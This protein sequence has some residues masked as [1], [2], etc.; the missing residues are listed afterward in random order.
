MHRTPSGRFG[1]EGRFLLVPPKLEN[2]SGVQNKWII[3]KRGKVT[4]S[5]KSDGK[6]ELWLKTMLDDTNHMVY[7]V[8]FCGVDGMLYVDMRVGTR[9]FC[10]FYSLLALFY[11][12]T[13]LTIARTF[14][15]Q[16]WNMERPNPAVKDRLVSIFMECVVAS[17][18][19]GTK[20][21]TIVYWTGAAMQFVMV[22]I[23]SVLSFI[24]DNVVASHF[25][26]KHLQCL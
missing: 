8:L 16:C 15:V 9:W 24:L 19:W 26:R 7:F 10:R 5:W 20:F 13:D 2:E 12:S 23:E 4:T 21:E 25:Q 11:L 14:C 6:P 22:I 3:W 17:A 1:W 18:S